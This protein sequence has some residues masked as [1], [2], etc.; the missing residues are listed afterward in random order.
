MKIQYNSADQLVEMGY[1]KHAVERSL[2]DDKFDD[3]YATYL[4]LQDKRR[5]QEAWGSSANLQSPSAAA[6]NGESGGI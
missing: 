1:P 3:I 2:E 5:E 6:T 4:L